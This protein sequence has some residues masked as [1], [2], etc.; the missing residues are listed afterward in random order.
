MAT[1]AILVDEY[2][3]IGPDQYELISA[4]GRAHA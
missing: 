2:Q 4:F 1:L 3:D